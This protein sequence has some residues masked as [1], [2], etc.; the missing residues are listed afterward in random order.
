[1]FL[2]LLTSADPVCY[3]GSWPSLLALGLP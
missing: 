3:L 1:M 2:I